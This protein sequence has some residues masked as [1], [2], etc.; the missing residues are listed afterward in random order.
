[1]EREKLRIAFRKRFGRELG[2]AI[3]DTLYELPG[4]AFKPQTCWPTEQAEQRLY[5]MACNADHGHCQ[6]I[7]PGG[8]DVLMIS[9]ELL[10][11]IIRVAAHY[12]K[13]QDAK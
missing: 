13:I 11:W 8:K 3:A 10:G 4:D 7:D 5:R 9:P 2:H 6:L 1:M 12:R